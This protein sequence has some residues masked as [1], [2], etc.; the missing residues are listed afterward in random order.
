MAIT[1]IRSIVI[2]VP[3]I[4]SGVLSVYYIVKNLN[5]HKTCVCYKYADTVVWY[6]SEC[7]AGRSSRCLVTVILSCRAGKTALSDGLT[8]GSK[9]DV[10]L[11]T[12]R[13]WDLATS[14]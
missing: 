8:S 3:S 5:V 1:T 14:F 12:A 11:A 2:T 4:R 7:L 6:N 10:S 13:R 9:K